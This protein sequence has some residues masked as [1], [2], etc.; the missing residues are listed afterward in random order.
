MQLAPETV[1]ARKNVVFI[2]NPSF[3]VESGMKNVRIRIRDKKMFGSGSGIKH[4]VSATITAILEKIGKS[5]LDFSSSVLESR[6]MQ[7]VSVSSH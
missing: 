1:K 4:L 2:F 5:S 6:F 3:Y 7:F